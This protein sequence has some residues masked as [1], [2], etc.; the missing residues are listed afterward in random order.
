[1]EYKLPIAET[2]IPIEGRK[3]FK[4]FIPKDNTYRFTRKVKGY[5]KESVTINAIT[6]KK[7]KLMLD[8]AISK[9]AYDIVESNTTNS[10][11]FILN[12]MEVRISDHSK[13]SFD[14]ISFVVNW[15]S[16]G[17]DYQHILEIF[18]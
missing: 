4:I 13:K 11:Y 8:W 7:I 15:N 2:T 6:K 1:M 10:V 3:V 17:K 5:H 14:G 18:M 12:G 9:G 16:S